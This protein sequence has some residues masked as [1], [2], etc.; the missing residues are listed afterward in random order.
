MESHRTPLSRLGRFTGLPV[1]W[2]RNVNG[3][4]VPRTN[5]INRDER[6]MARA[7]QI[8]RR[9]LGRTSPNPM[10]GAVI[11]N[12]G[13][14]VGEGY[15]RSA[16][17]P[18]AEVEALRKAR[19]RSRGGTL[20]VTLEP[21]NHTG[22]TPPCCDAIIASGLSRVVAAAKDPNPLTNGRGLARLRQAGIEVITGVLERASLRLN[23]PF[24]K[25]ITSGMPF[26]VAKVGQSLDGK[27]ATA[28]GQSRWISSLASRRL[29]H[30]W[31]SRVD[32]IL[33][34]I[35]TVLQDDPLLTVRGAPRRS[36]RPIKVIVD[37]R[38]R[39]P[40]TARCLSSRSPAPTL[41]ATTV[42]SE[43]KRRMLARCGAEVLE[44]PARQGRVPLRRLCRRLVRRGVQSILVEGGGEVLAS[45]LA[46]RIVD[47]I[48]F[49][50]APILIGGRAA[51]TSFSGS[52]ASHLSRA[53]RLTDVT[54][55]RLG[56]DLCVEARVVYPTGARG[57][58]QGARVLQKSRAPR[59][60]P[61][62]P[63]AGR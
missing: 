50:I 7:L 62:A 56:P 2:R 36:G 21:C 55:R 51:P 48:A 29:A 59:P 30:Q 4:T 26:V 35:N 57:R 44:F 16:G 38:L 33:I 11:V 40:T 37:S 27:I 18:H 10:V 43:T 63:R 28:S 52:G 54:Y 25:A 49:F 24:R 42:R 39:T 12:R 53:I 15:H 20:Y 23:E 5:G 6:Y 13:R 31:R 46:E 34:G 1:E 22:R 41:I 8:A 32:A 58:R 14:V 60:A 47:R 3:P 45:A 17:A 61:R 19:E 9:A